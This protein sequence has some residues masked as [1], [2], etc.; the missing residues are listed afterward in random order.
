MQIVVTCTNRK[1]LPVPAALQFRN[2]CGATTT[3]RHAFWTQA[4]Q[5]ILAET[6]A[7]ADLYGGD[8]WQ[9]A[10]SLPDQVCRHGGAERPELWVTSAGYGLVPELACLKPYTATFAPRY[11]DTV[12]RPSDPGDS[13]SAARQ[14]WSLLTRAPG[15]GHDSP[16]SLAALAAGRA[17]EVLLVVASA[18]YLAA[19]RDDLVAARASLGSPELLLIISVGG[20]LTGPLAQNLL[21]ADARLRLL[22]GGTLTALNLRVARWLLQQV[23]PL[24]LT[25]PL[26]HAL[27]T[28]AL[29]ALPAWTPAAGL[30]LRDAEVRQFIISAQAEQPALSR[31]A[32]LRRL[33]TEGYACEQTRFATIM[34]SVRESTRGST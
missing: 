10:R 11:P 15:P 32:L 31:T 17:N 23:P 24:E 33:R 5:D 1:R 13:S 28:H 8:A 34:Q 14:W 26:A 6:T 25:V 12:I 2:I 16:R 21:P 30:R 18:S 3:A 9:I 4:L 27:L 29:A 22:V 7:A 20:S 19:L